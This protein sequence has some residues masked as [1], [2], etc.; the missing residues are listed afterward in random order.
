MQA[1]CLCFIPDCPL[2]TLDVPAGYAVA[3]ASPFTGANI[4]ASMVR[5]GVKTDESLQVAPPSSYGSGICN[6]YVPNDQVYTRF[7]YVI[8]YLARQGFYILIDNHA[9]TDPTVVNNPAVSF[10]TLQ[11]VSKNCPLPTQK[12]ET[13]QQG[14]CD[15]C[16]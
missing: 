11:S 5:Q 9:N 3:D 4:C 10:S 15:I 7:L 1:V 6:D 13:E 2:K 14:C 16:R 8:G 12:K